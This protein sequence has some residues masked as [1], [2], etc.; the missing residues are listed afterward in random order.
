MKQAIL[1]ISFLLSVTFSR[2]QNIDSLFTQPQVIELSI[3]TP[4]PRLKETFQIT[5]DINHLRANIFKSL[6]GKVQLSN[7]IGSEDNG[8]ITMNVNALKKGKNEIGPLEFTLDKTKYSTN[9]ITYEVI[10]PLP[11]TDK[12]LWIRKVNTSDSTFCIIIE[13]RIPADSKTTKETDNSISLTTE[14]EYNEIAKFKVGYSI[15]GVS[16]FNSHS[17]T[18]FSSVEI[19][20]EDR[21]FMY[22]YSVYYFNIDD[23]KAKIKITKD[24]FEN[25]PPDYKFENIVIQ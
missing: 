14:P 15:E 23:K 22:G 1:F 6:A 10:D 13:Q 16:G 21:Q 7:D 19:K 25:I 3:S 5:L 9:K 24:K 17:N 4:Q 18:N 20:G 11:N 2:T 12:G 8:Q